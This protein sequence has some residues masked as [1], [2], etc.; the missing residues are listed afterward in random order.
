MTNVFLARLLVL[1]LLAFSSARF[2]FVKKV[3]KDSLS[4]L[5]AV[6]LIVSLLNIP[7]FG[8]SVT[9][10]G[11][12]F[13]SLF[14][15]IWNVRALLRV[16][17]ELVIDHYGTWFKIISSI[18]LVL[19]IAAAV[20][21]IYFRPAKSNE[22]TFMIQKTTENYC[23]TYSDG[24]TKAG[25]LPQ[26][27][28]IRLF[29]YTSLHT[30]GAVHG[31]VIFIPPKTA[32]VSEYCGFINKLAYDGYTVITAEFN[33]TGI[34]WL[35]G[36][37]NLS[38]ARKFFFRTMK[39]F[40]PED[41]KLFLENSTM[42]RRDEWNALIDLSGVNENDYVFL[43]TE[44]D[45]TGDLTALIQQH[46]ALTDGAFD[47]A[48]VPG[49]KTAGFGPLENTSPLFAAKFGLKPDRTF[50]ISSRIAAALEEA[51]S[52]TLTDFYSLDE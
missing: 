27:A 30:K 32:S 31:T 41:Y 21:V 20:I 49:Y 4:V 25:A 5:P 37:K 35:R 15:F 6:A 16:M 29:R 51:V 33:V 17:G 12:F 40:H 7:A 26:K 2:I 24:F 28:D 45:A 18:N 34:K 52:Y 3:L 1:G 14:V 22:K 10:A 39:Y 44:D 19:I 50:Y 11:L 13:L 23:G 43:V 42:R 46:N 48:E 47:L 36:L 8:L 38:F 9:E